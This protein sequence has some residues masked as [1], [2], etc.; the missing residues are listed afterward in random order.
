MAFSKV[1]GQQPLEGLKQRPG[2]LHS[3]I[4]SQPLPLLEGTT[5]GGGGDL[6]K[7]QAV[8]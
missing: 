8:L 6:A 5:G 7:G 3:C 1:L 2:T 4:Y